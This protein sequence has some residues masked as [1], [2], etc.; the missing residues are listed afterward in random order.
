VPV[1]L[2]NAVALIDKTDDPAVDGPAHLRFNVAAPGGEALG[3][4]GVT[5]FEFDGNKLRRVQGWLK[6]VRLSPT[7][8]AEITFDLNR[9]PRHSGRWWQS[10]GRPGRESFGAAAAR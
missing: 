6:N 9:R 1:V 7:T 2:T 3:S 10:A 5:L 4:L 8:P